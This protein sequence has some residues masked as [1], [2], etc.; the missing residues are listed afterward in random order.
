MRS[1]LRRFFLLFFGREVSC[2]FFFP[3]LP[4]PSLL[5]VYIII[6]YLLLTPIKDDRGENNCVWEGEGRGEVKECML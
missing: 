1:I 4:F 2:L 6:F 5:S 3:F